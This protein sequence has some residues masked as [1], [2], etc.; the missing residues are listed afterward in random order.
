LPIQFESPPEWKAGKATAFSLVAFEA[1][2]DSKTVSIAV[3]EAGGAVAANVNRWRGML[4][5]SPWSDDEVQQHLQKIEVGGRSGWSVELVN[6][7]LAPP[8]ATYAVIVPHDGGS[9]FIT[10]KGDASVAAAERDRFQSFVKS[11]RFK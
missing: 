4:R 6:E 1:T 10:M 8:Q 2:S 7:S 3:T 11:I 9:L 5:L